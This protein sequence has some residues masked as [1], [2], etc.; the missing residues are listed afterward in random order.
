MPGNKAKAANRKVIKM[1]NI[2][3]RPIAGTKHS[4]VLVDDKPYVDE[5]KDG[6]YVSKGEDGVMHIR[7]GLINEYGIWANSY[8]EVGKAKD[9]ESAERKIQDYLNVG[10]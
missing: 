3:L 1:L 7:S 9:E 5:L 4:Q 10:I 2:E 8:F 6:L